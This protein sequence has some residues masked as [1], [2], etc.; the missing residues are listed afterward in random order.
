MASS[1]NHSSSLLVIIIT[2][3]AGLLPLI[4]RSVSMPSK[5]GMNWSKSTRSKILSFDCDIPSRPL[6]HVAME[7]PFSFKK[8]IWG[9]RRSISSSIQR[10]FPRDFS[11]II[12]C[13]N[14]S[15]AGLLQNRNRSYLVVIVQTPSQ[16]FF[17][18]FFLK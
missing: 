17:G 10:I 9:L 5:P 16:S 1:I 13:I 6:E 3:S 4:S 11:I 15:E 2:G 14:Y 18:G 7:Y 8:R 12:R